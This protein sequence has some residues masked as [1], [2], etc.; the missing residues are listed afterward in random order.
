MKNYSFEILVGTNGLC[1]NGCIGRSTAYFVADHR[2]L[3][4]TLLCNEI[5]STANRS[6]GSKVC[7]AC[8][9]NWICPQGSLW[10]PIELSHD[11]Y[12][13]WGSA[14]LL[15][16]VWSWSSADSKACIDCFWKQNTRGL[17]PLSP[18]GSGTGCS[19]LTEA[20]IIDQFEPPKW[21]IDG[22]ADLRLRLAKY[23]YC[24]YCVKQEFIE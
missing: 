13:V 18:P 14:A 21:S 6:L 11:A 19:N 7:W 12:S 17:Q 1:T 5:G 8:C 23:S 22:L 4:C 3:Y 16:D 9:G 24:I 10:W 2:S 15:T 20:M